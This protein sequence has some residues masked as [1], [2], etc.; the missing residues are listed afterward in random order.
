MSGDGTHIKDRS[1]ESLKKQEAPGRVTCHFEL[2]EVEDVRTVEDQDSL[3]RWMA[4][5]SRQYTD[6]EKARVSHVEWANPGVPPK[7][8]HI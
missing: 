8:K 7:P 6:F 1:R 4:M 5:M 2:G 3:G